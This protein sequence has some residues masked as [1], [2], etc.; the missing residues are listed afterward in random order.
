MKNRIWYSLYD[1]VYKR[2]NLI[3]AFEQVKKN[4]GAPG[5]DKV[6]I[7][8]YEWLLEDNLEVLQ[9]KLKTKSYCPK[10]VRRKMIK[11]ENG[12]Q[13]P[14]GIP[15][16]EDRVVQAAIRNI[17]EPIFEEEFLPCSYGF[18]PGISAH[19]AL[20]KVT[21]HLSAGYHYVI[22]ADLQS[23]FDTIP[24]DKLEQQIRKRVTDGSVI[25]LIHQ[26]LSAGVMEGE[27]YQETPGGAPQGGVLSPLLSNIYL[28]QLDQLMTE[29]GH[30]IVRF[31]DD[32]IILCKS[33]KGADRVMRSVTRFLEEELCLTVNQEKT[34]VVY[35]R[36]EP[37]TFLGYEFIGDIRRIDPKKEIK[38]KKRVKEITRRNQTVDI[39]TLI[40]T[41]LNPYLRGWANYFR[42]GNVK[43]K[44]KDWDSWI[45]RRLRMVQLRSWRKVKNLHRLL[46]RKGWREESLRGIRMLAWR[47]SKS[48][49][50]HAALDNQF[51][52]ELGLVSLVSVYDERYL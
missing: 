19:M 17:L 29:R 6:T 16:V 48:P 10:P 27:R 7:E 36:K 11:K 43:T 2:T 9:Q 13:R 21:E 28:H 40:K 50:A 22:D 31:A 18:R 32:F 23:Y 37:F 12:K 3:S 39:E 35:A 44:F 4:K 52:S 20:D 26:F 1:K 8:D 15:T 34:K 41:K 14:L 33:Q 38:F 42:Y 30:R 46:R 49:M 5:V 51:F 47:S 25:Q 45:R 24:R